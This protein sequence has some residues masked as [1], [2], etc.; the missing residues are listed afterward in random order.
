MTRARIIGAGGLHEMMSAL[1]GDHA[2]DKPTTHPIDPRAQAMELR[3]RFRRASMTTKLEPGILCR[4]KRGM[5]MLKVPSLILFWRW[6][7]PAD[8]QDAAII[9]KAVSQK[10]I[11]RTDC[12]VAFLDTD[13]DLNIL[14]YESWRLEPC[15]DF[16]D[17]AEVPG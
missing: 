7:D 8:V 16:P 15:D 4:E 11:F 6:L 10:H 14:D 2:D 9:A 5:S 12:M 1:T 13:G 3:D 17:D